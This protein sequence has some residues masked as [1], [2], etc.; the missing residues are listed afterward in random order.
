MRVSGSTGRREAFVGNKDWRSEFT[1]R[2]Q[3][4]IANCETYAKDNPAG[5]PGHNLMV[6]IAKM[7]A[8]LDKREP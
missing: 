5:L 7:A 1:E 8:K 4:L 6:I 3:A 2:E